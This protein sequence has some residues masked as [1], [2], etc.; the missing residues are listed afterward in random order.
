MTECDIVTLSHC[1]Y[2]SLDVNKVLLNSIPLGVS[3]IF[4]YEIFVILISKNK[5][6]FAADLPQNENDE[7]FIFRKSGSKP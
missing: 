5:D 2:S 6:Q 3:F 7:E 4:S 1:D